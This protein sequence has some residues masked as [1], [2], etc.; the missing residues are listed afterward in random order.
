MLIAN[1]PF[2]AGRLHCPDRADFVDQCNRHAAFL[3]SWSPDSP[4]ADRCDLSPFLICP[5]S[6]SSSF[7]DRDVAEMNSSLL[8]EN[9]Q[10]LRV[11]NRQTLPVRVAI[12]VTQSAKPQA[13]F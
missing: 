10:V 9:R 13:A 6:F 12:L 5:S 7:A 8:P 1:H 4:R 2:R 11:V 3:C